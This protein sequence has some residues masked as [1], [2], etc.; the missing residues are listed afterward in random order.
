MQSTFANSRNWRRDW[1]FILNKL[2][3]GSSGRND[4]VLKELSETWSILK[5]SE[6]RLIFDTQQTETWSIFDTQGIIGDAINI[7]YARNYWRY[8]CYL[9]FNTAVKR[10]SGR[11]LCSCID[12]WIVHNQYFILNYLPSNQKACKRKRWTIGDTIRCCLI[13]VKRPDDGQIN[14]L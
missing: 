11:G 6:A 1:Y 4:L 13:G 7:Q 9:T 10:A 12:D 2:V 14:L 8:N 5:E 3:S